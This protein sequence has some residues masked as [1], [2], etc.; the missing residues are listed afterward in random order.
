MSVEL[1]DGTFT[2]PEPLEDAIETLRDLKEQ[3]VALHVGTLDELRAKK[4]EK[5]LKERIEELEKKVEMQ[6]GVKS[7]LL[8]IPNKDEIEKY[9]ITEEE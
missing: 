5:T 8:T 4:E 3:A 1:K 9:S 6:V 2:N 7:S